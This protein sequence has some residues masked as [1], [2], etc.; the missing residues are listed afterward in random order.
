MTD[1]KLYILVKHTRM[2]YVKF[3]ARYL[4]LSEAK[5][6]HSHKICTEVSS[7]VP[8]LSDDV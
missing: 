6:S 2:T 8:H 5:A 7:S 4:C 1:K 3:V